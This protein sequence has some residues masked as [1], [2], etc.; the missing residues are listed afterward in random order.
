MYGRIDDIQALRQR[1]DICIVLSG[2]SGFGKSTILEELAAASGRN[3][4]P[5]SSLQSLKARPGSLQQGLLDGLTDVT[6]QILTFKHTVKDAVDRLA[7]AARSMATEHLNELG[8]ALAKEV[9]SLVRSKLGPEFGNAIGEYV[10]AVQKEESKSLQQRI[11]AQVDKDVLKVILTLAREVAKLAPDGAIWLLIDNGEHLGEA[12]FAQLLDLPDEVPAGVHVLVGFRSNTPAYN[13]KI[14]KLVD[15][16]W[17]ESKVA[18]ISV[19]SVRNWLADEQL[20]TGWEPR[21]S[22]LSSGSPLIIADLVRRLRNAG[23]LDQLTVDDAVGR[24]T[25]EILGNV[26]IPVS[27]AARKLSAFFE[28]L[29]RDQVPDF[30]GID[31]D[32]WVEIEQ[33][34][35][36]AGI[37]SSRLNGQRWFH[38]QRRRAI[39][40]GLEA[41]DQQRFARSAVEH[42]KVQLRTMWAP[43]DVISLAE[44]GYAYPGALTADDDLHAVATSTDAEIALVGALIELSE[45]G[46]PG[47]PP[48]VEAGPLFNYVRSNYAAGLDL[49][50]ALTSLKGRGVIGAASNEYATVIVPNLGG[51]ALALLA[52]RAGIRFGRVPILGLSSM[53][54]EIFLR[55]R[56]SPFKD[57]TFGIGHPSASQ[58]FDTFRGMQ[59][60]RNSTP[61]HVVVPSDREPGLVIRARHGDVNLYCAAAFESVSDRDGAGKQVVQA[62]G[63]VFGQIFRTTLCEPIPRERVR[64]LRWPNALKLITNYKSDLFGSE[65]RLESEGEISAEET[66]Q[67]WSEV[68]RL[69]RAFSSTDERMAYNLERRLRLAYFAEE[70]T[71]AVFFIRGDNDGT[72]RIEALPDDVG[73]QS[74]RWTARVAER[75]NLPSSDS[76]TGYRLFMGRFLN[77]KD[78]VAELLTDLYKEGQ[79][80][81]KPQSRTRVVLDEQS[82]SSMILD[83]HRQ[84]LTDARLLHSSVSISQGVP[85]VG[86]NY[87]VDVHLNEDLQDSERFFRWGVECSSYDTDDGEPGFVDLR[88]VPHG[89]HALARSHDELLKDKSNMRSRRTSGALDYVLPQLLGYDEESVRFERA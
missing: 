2:E 23:N 11:A 45:L 54:F 69:V 77:S 67:R 7:R 14:R 61:G 64:I 44:L 28:P 30:L 63:Q 18:G 87:I 75:L 32:E 15:R 21:I 50:E 59:I 78:P 46:N 88:I 39:W 60:R 57:A 4:R 49:E 80:Y 8:T 5:A 38:D 48:A 84:A 68:Y 86:R 17:G 35:W 51:P 19:K 34:L 26:P 1:S 36:D 81:N 22:R 76:V 52:G 3:G 58:L 10:K 43:D 74:S 40:S 9:L 82:L 65:I 16:G 41:P 56:M 24:V 70:G 55:Q 85:P 13:E 71:L 66:I 42:L 83:S 37:F 29:P 6:G 12:D 47:E 27:G 53:L 25:A 79:A 62:H 89:G 31:R 33:R 73:H 20:D 72:L